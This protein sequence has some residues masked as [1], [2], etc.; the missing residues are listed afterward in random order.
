MKAYIGAAV[1]KYC[2]LAARTL[3]SSVKRLTQMSGNTAMTLATAPTETNATTPAIQQILRARAIRSAPIAMPT[4]GTEAMPTANEIDVSMNSS[5]APM[6]KPARISV[7]KLASMWVK[8]LMV[9]TDC[10]GE[11][12]EMAPTF[13]MS[14]NIGM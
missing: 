13:R 1:D 11:K 4:I 5:R 2:R 14:M 3:A 8:M 12:Q 9:R 7:P 6:P 10:S